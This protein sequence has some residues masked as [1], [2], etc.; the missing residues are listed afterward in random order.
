MHQSDNNKP[1][2]EGAIEYAKGRMERELEPGLTYHNFAHTFN[3]VLPM[4]LKLADLY[5]LSGDDVML[6]AVAAAYHDI[7][8]VVQGHEHEAIGVEIARQVLPTY[9]FNTELIE[10]IG[11]MIMATRLPQNPSNLLEEI[12]VDADMDSLGREDFWSRNE[13]L[14]VELARDGELLTIEEWYWKQLEFLKS[15]TFFTDGAR[16][17]RRKQK[18]KNIK[19]L[20]RRLAQFSEEF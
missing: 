3:E 7:G 11:E 5:H 13:D 19:E 15:H 17:L 2:V 16:L 8:W 4:T 14:R 18:K 1:D 12:L 9:G 10:R 20:K 6:L